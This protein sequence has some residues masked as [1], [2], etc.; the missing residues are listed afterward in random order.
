MKV[1]RSPQGKSPSEQERQNAVWLLSSFSL[2]HTAVALIAF[3]SDSP[4]AG[5]F[6]WVAACLYGGLALMAH[7]TSSLPRLYQLV[8][9]VMTILVQV[10]LLIFARAAQ[11]IPTSL[12]I[13]CGMVAGLAL[14]WLEFRQAV[15]W[16]LGV[17]LPV[18][19]AGFWFPFAD[20]A[21]IALTGMMLMLIAYM[22]QYNRG[23]L[24]I[25]S[26]QDH[27]KN[28]AERDPLTGLYN[29]RAL[30]EQAQRRLSTDTVMVLFDI[31]HFKQIN[32]TY[33]HLYGDEILTYVAHCLHDA[34]PS[35]TLLARWGGEEF[36][37]MFSGLPACAQDDVARAL[38]RIEHTTFKNGVQVTVSAGGALQPEAADLSALILLA[39]RRLY[40]AKAAGRNCARWVSG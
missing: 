33:G 34:L 32:D 30:L 40:A 18:L 13:S 36:L 29:R 26:Q 3:N 24:H 15:G 31:D 8:L 9:L 19:G 22:R 11:H 25:Q 35:G 16:S 10:A 37:A 6:S 27:L 5:N 14:T 38:Q 7:R 23:L 4:Q 28:L 12:F 39:D 20:P 17:L 2:G 1:T 21:T